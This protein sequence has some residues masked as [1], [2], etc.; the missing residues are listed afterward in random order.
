MKA[1]QIF[2]WTRTMISIV[3]ILIRAV[4]IIHLNIDFTG[5]LDIFKV[6]Y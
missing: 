1:N 6:K 3:L 5:V 4:N 2:S